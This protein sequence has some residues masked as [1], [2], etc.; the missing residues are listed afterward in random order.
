VVSVSSR[1][2]T[3][4]EYISMAVASRRALQHWRMFV[5]LALAALNLGVD[6]RKPCRGQV[7]GD[8][9]GAIARIDPAR[10]AALHENIFFSVLFVFSTEI[11]NGP[12]GGWHQSVTRSRKFR[13][14][15]AANSANPPCSARLL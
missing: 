10:P 8:M 15:P 4:D 1:R 7:C 5:P 2:R 11:R 12:K 6:L 13:F 9:H 3:S 14:S